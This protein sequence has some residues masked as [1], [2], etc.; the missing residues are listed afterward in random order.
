MVEKAIMPCNLYSI[1][2]YTTKISISTSSIDILAQHEG[3]NQHVNEINNSMHEKL[4]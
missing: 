1:K 2:L 4:L 3:K